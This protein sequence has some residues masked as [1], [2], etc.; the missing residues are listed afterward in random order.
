MTT[1]D[2]EIIALDSWGATPGRPRWCIF[3]KAPEAQRGVQPCDSNFFRVHARLSRASFRRTLCRRLGTR[4][5]RANHRD[6]HGPIRFMLRLTHQT[7][8]VFRRTGASVEI[9]PMQFKF[10]TSAYDPDRPGS[11]IRSA[12]SVA[13]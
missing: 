5:G 2:N 8:L 4:S 6:P 12:Q 11:F 9:A 7:A 1:K 3:S 10:A 13:D